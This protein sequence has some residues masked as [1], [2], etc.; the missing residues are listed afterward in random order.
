VQVESAAGTKVSVTFGRIVKLPLPSAVLERSYV[1]FESLYFN[2][3]GMIV[4]KLLQ[5]TKQLLP[6]VRDDVILSSKLTVI[7]FEHPLNALL[8]MEITELGIVTDVKEVQ[9]ENED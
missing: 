4:F 9:S 6:I 1:P 2:P 3:D 8:P 7:R 5:L